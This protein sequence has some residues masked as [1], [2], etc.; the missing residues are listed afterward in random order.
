MSTMTAI[1]TANVIQS[2]MGTGSRSDS[3]VGGAFAAS[4]PARGAVGSF[5]ASAEG[6]L[7]PDYSCSTPGAPMR[8]DDASLSG[9]GAAMRPPASINP[10]VLAATSG[11]VA[12]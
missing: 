12:P 8:P 10:A 2:Q 9:S 4:A 11:A 7:T 5:D 1:P 3:A 6:Y